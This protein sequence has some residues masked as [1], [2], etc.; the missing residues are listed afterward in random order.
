MAIVPSNFDNLESILR[1]S[2]IVFPIAMAYQE[3]M[4]AFNH[5][6]GCKGCQND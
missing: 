1:I 6:F 2:D 4:Q 3:A 5:Q